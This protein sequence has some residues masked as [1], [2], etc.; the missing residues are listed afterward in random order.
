MQSSVTIN[1]KP[2]FYR[3]VWVSEVTFKKKKESG[4]FKSPGAIYYA[5]HKF[6]C[7]VQTGPKIFCFLCR[8]RTGSNPT[9]SF[10]VSSLL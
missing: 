3:W 2:K 4:R 5:F 10:N 6:S 8:Y 9:A 7:S 1:S